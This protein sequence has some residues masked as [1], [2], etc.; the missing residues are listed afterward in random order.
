M[1]CLDDNFKKMK[2]DYESGMRLIDLE[3][4]Y[5][6]PSATLIR[7]LKSDGVFKPSLKR[8]NN[9]ELSYLKKNYSDSDWN[10]IISELNRWSKAEIT[11]K[12]STLKLHREIFFWTS[13]EIEILKTSY[14]QS[15]PIEEIQSKLNYKHTKESIYAKANKIGLSVRNSW[16]NEELDILRN[17]YETSSTD[18]ILSLLKNRNIDVIRVYANQMG[19]KSKWWNDRSVSIESYRDLSHYLRCHNST[20]KTESIKACNYRCVISGERFGE[21]HHLVSFNSILS[22]TLSNYNI[23]LKD[24]FSEYT[25]PEL[26]D[27]SSK[28]EGTQNKYPLGVCLKKELHREFHNQYGYGGNTPE[29]FDCFLQKQ[30]S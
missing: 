30:I 25:F 1:N 6:E 5:S 23:K 21:I 4:K 15:L 20:W 19:C 22:E 12:A 24:S 9:D 27:I 14:S 7:L 13:D 2:T 28:F 16:T 3:R 18:E 29:Q 26:V 11:H 10:E 17:N 8:W